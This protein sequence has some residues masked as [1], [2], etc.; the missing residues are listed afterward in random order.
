[1]LAEPARHVTHL[2]GS[3]FCSRKETFGG[4]PRPTCRAD[5][6]GCRLRRNRSRP[7]V[8][9]R[10]VRPAGATARCDVSVR[11]DSATSQLPSSRARRLR[12]I[13]CGGWQRRKLLARRKP[14]AAR[15]D[16]CPHRRGRGRG[17]ACGSRRREDGRPPPPGPPRG[18][19][20]PGGGVTEDRLDRGAP[21]GR[22]NP[23][24]RRGGRPVPSL[25][26]R[27]AGSAGRHPRRLRG[28]CGPAHPG[29]RRPG[30]GPPVGQ[31]GTTGHADTPLLPIGGAGRLLP[32]QLVAQ[33]L[34]AAPGCF[35]SGSGGPW[36]ADRQAE[37]GRPPEL[38]PGGAGAGR[39][40]HATA[41]LAA[42][43]LG[44]E[45]IAPAVRADIFGQVG[46]VYSA[47][48]GPGVEIAAGPKPSASPGTS[49]GHDKG[50]AGGPPIGGFWGT[51][52]AIGRSGGSAGVAGVEGGDVAG[53]WH[54][55]RGEIGRLPRMYRDIRLGRAE[56]SCPGRPTPRRSRRA[57]A[58]WWRTRPG[59]VVPGPR[60]VA[61]VVVVEAWHPLDRAEQ[62]IHHSAVGGGVLIR[63]VRRAG[64][65][66]PGCLP[67][68]I[69][70][71][72][73]RHRGGRRRGCRGRRGRCR[74]RNSRV[75]R[76]GGRRGLPRGRGGR[77]GRG[78]SR[79][80]RWS[81][82]RGRPGG[83]RQQLHGQIDGQ[84]EQTRRTK[85]G[86]QPSPHDVP[87]EAVGTARCW[88]PGAGPSSGCPSGT[89]T[90]AA[91]FVRAGA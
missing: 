35:P 61:Q 29:H 45:P 86:Q 16:S 47:P 21:G 43:Q 24:L 78:W 38:G 70:L 67:A 68:A 13:S 22:P 60:V 56:G 90:V 10:P 65:A 6:G 76:R 41:R 57:R 33:R 66:G 37:G 91:R 19:R 12:R 20:C 87:G 40:E 84:P 25:P 34:P 82:R 7:R 64:I 32:D 69:G 30:T 31:P 5:L 50:R 2:L 72:R 36:H 80:G 51:G 54:D 27:R 39:A 59:H 8:C 28:G 55:T 1:M 11:P 71:A 83:G 75:L 74:G 79:G 9:D 63:G 23:V 89:A 58:S 14:R 62:A 85:R 48:L 81:G 73:V 53:L 17:G 4:S 44:D 52:A 18:D 46:R 26:R 88:V 49:R 42:P 77:G 15:G 3:P